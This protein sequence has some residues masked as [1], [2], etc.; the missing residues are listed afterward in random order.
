MCS[1]DLPYRIVYVPDPV[2]WTEAPEQARFLRGQRQRWYRGCVET[3]LAHR[4]M[5]GNPRYRAVGLIALPAMLVFE[6][7]GPAIELSGYAVTV[8]ALIIGSLSP[9][10]FL[11]FL[12]ISVLYGQV[13]TVGAVLLEDVTPNR[14]PV[15][16][17][18][19]RMRWHAWAENLG[20]R[21]VLQVWRI[22]GLWQLARKSGWGT[23]ERAGLS[24]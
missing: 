23:M 8:A 15:W 4:A 21:Q 17:E 10:T 19:R 9:V 13:L 6:I 1:S 7:V 18:L 3:V 20:Y 12:A 22:G 11:L 14:H 24:N 2:C 16:A 5:L